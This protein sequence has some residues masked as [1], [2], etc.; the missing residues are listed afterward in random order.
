MGSGEREVEGRGRPQV[1]SPIDVHTVIRAIGGSASQRGRVLPA[2]S[3]VTAGAGA[4]GL[5]GAART[6]GR[7]FCS[8][9]TDRLIA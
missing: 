7:W 4:C 6:G 5:F 3:A 1:E 2:L 9:G 8:A